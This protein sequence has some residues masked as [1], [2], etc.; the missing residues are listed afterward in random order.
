MTC[1]PIQYH[2]RS[3]VVVVV[4]VDA[5]FPLGVLIPGERRSV[6]FE[7]LPARVGISLPTRSKIEATF[8]CSL[9]RNVCTLVAQNKSNN[10]SKKKER[11]FRLVS[12]GTQ[13]VFKRTR[14]EKWGREEG[15]S[16]RENVDGTGVRQPSWSSS[17]PL[18]RVQNVRLAKVERGAR[19]KRHS[20]HP[21]KFMSREIQES[22]IIESLLLG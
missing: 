19:R 17:K 16:A 2:P 15:K 4:V 12:Y 13:V 5:L 22:G 7:L 1:V 11:N 14:T 21:T 10:D 8:R 20:A 6:N 3:L 9:C 18:V